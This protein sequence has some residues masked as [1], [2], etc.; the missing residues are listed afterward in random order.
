MSLMSV[1]DEHQALVDLEWLSVPTVELL[2]HRGFELI[3]L[4]P[5]ERSRLGVN[6]LAL[7][8]GRLLSIAENERTNDM[9]RGHGFEVWTFPGTEICHNGSG[10]PTCLT[11]P[12][13]RG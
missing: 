9:L 5:E 10:G 8:R 12:L 3:P 11:R 6:V 7:G 2:Q 1:L 4:V 13:L